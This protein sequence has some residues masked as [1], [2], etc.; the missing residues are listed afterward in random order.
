MCA[1]FS[2]SILNL[3]YKSDCLCY[4]GVGVFDSTEPIEG[5]PFFRI[6]FF[7]LSIVTAAVDISGF[8]HESAEILATVS[9]S[10]K[11]RL[12]SIC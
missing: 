11:T 6:N 3:Y 1:S 12:P 8:T 9:S 2:P 4:I 10:V 7:N 5:F